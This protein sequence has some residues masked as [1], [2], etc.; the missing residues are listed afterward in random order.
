[1]TSDLETVSRCDLCSGTDTARA[2]TCR[3]SDTPSLI[4]E[5]RGRRIFSIMRCKACGL[6]FVTP[7]YVRDKLLRLY[8]DAYFDG[9]DTTSGR[10]RA[11][12]WNRNTRIAGY[13]AEVALFRKYLPRG[14]VFDA[15][16]GPGWFADALGPDYAVTGGDWSARAV[17]LAMERSACREAHVLDI[18]QDHL[19]EARYDG[20]VMIQVLDHLRAPLAALKNV[21]RA[22]LPGGVLLIARLPNFTAPL[23]R[24]F[25]NDFQLLAPNHLYY[26]TRSTI[27]NALHATGLEC[28]AIRYPFFST[29]FF[30]PSWF[31]RAPFAVARRLCGGRPKP[32]PGPGNV[33]SVVAIKRKEH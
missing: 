2:R 21:A 12:F 33:M 32:P 5:M 4:A 18:E 8:G 7:R 23:A 19:G 11:L 26:F 29:P 16:C 17:A 25:G 28:L 13:R 27:R 1:M 30:T 20:A 22:L 9:S 3:E 14:K 6:A 15:G 10:A 31:V 24:L